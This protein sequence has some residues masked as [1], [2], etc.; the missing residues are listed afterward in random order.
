MPLRPSGFVFR[1]HHLALR[2]RLALDHVPPGRPLRCSHPLRRR[3]RPLL[4]RRLRRLRPR[5]LRHHAPEFVIPTINKNKNKNKQKYVSRED[6]IYLR[7]SYE[8]KQ[9]SLIIPD[10]ECIIPDSELI[11]RSRR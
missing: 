4:R 9:C 11:I 10:S 6:C 8:P 1:G 7:A 2:R 5:H 3:R